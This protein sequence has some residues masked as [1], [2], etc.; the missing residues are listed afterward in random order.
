MSSLVYPRNISFRGFLS[1][2]CSVSNLSLGIPL[3]IVG[4]PFII[5]FITTLSIDYSSPMTWSNHRLLL[6]FITRT[7]CSIFIEILLE[8]GDDEHQ[9]FQHFTNG[10]FILTWLQ[11]ICCNTKLHAVE[12]N[13]L[14]YIRNLYVENRAK[15]SVGPTVVLQ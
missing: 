3:G 1:E 10:T 5:N 9:T 12:A 6:L 4:L 15:N 14:Q 7:R 11:L 2:L 13:I 8:K